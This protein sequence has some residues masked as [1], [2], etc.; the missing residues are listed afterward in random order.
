MRRVPGDASRCRNCRQLLGCRPTRRRAPTPYA[1]MSDTPTTNSMPLLATTP[2]M[3]GPIS[4]DPADPA[5]ITPAAVTAPL[6]VSAT[7]SGPIT[8][9]W[10]DLTDLVTDL[11]H[12][13][14]ELLHLGGPVISVLAILSVIALTIVLVKLWQFARAGVGRHGRVEQS[15]MLWCQRRPQEAIDALQSRRSPTARLVQLAMTGVRRPGLDEA[16]LREE[17]V[18]VASRQLEALRAY[19]RALEVIATLSP[20]LGLL[21]TVLGMIQAFQEL[22]VS[23]SQVDPALLSGGIWQALLTTALGLAVAIP[24]VLAHSWLERRVERCGHAM[25]DAVTRVFTFSLTPEA[26]PANPE[27]APAPEAAGG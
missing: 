22:A 2:P 10:P 27:V 13:L 20:L 17:L 12:R 15:L 26:R 25:E 6:P 11:P 23:G 3:A 14:G 7:D 8:G 19:L 18:R 24:V 21:G 9:S 4:A 5:G 16:M 1:N